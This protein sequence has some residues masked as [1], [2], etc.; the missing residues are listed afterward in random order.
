MR[1]F[2]QQGRLDNSEFTLA[3]SPAEQ[4]QQTAPVVGV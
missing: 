4:Q 1:P 2:R 3:M